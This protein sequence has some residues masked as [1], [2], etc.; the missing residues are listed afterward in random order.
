[1]WPIGIKYFTLGNGI[2][3]CLI[4]LYSDSNQT[5]NAVFK[6]LKYS[7]VKINLKGVV[8]TSI[9]DLPTYDIISRYI[10]QSKGL[11]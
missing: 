6:H 8:R 4:D 3:D 7:I 10:Y 2:V 11:V 9:K 1:M 5:S